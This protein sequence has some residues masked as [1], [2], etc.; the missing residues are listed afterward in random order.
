[1]VPEGVQKCVGQ[2]GIEARNFFFE[3]FMWNGMLWCILSGIFAKRCLQDTATVTSCLQ[4][5]PIR[6]NGNEPAYMATS[7]KSPFAT[8]GKGLGTIFSSMALMQG[9]QL[10]SQVQQVENSV[11]AKYMGR[12]RGQKSV[13]ATAR[14]QQRMYTVCWFLK[15]SY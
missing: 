1:M 12:P 6:W 11:W 5:K 13:W 10:G 7:K 4:A 15:R 14:L 2:K 9:R 8:W 3:F